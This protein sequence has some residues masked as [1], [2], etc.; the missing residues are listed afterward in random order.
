MEMFFKNIY[1]KK[2][3][4]FIFSDIIFNAYFKIQEENNFGNATTKRLCKISY[5]KL[6]VFFLYQQKGIS[7]T[8]K[9]YL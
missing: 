4:I 7:I 9:E 6:C 2:K 5:N 1:N 3:K 8:A